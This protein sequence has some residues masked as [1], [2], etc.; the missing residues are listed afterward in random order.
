MKHL[1]G[2]VFSCPECGQTELRNPN[3]D[4]CPACGEETYQM[5]GG[6][7][8]RCPRCTSKRRLVRDP[9]KAQRR[10]RLPVAVGFLWILLLSMIASAYI[11]QA[12]T[13]EY[14]EVEL[15]PDPA[16]AD[17]TVRQELGEDDIGQL[18]TTID[19][20][21]EDLGED[22]P[23]GTYYGT[24]IQGSGF[25][26]R[27]RPY[28]LPKDD[29]GKTGRFSYTM[30]AAH[31]NFSASIIMSGCSEWW[32]KVPVLASSI[33]WSHGLYVAL[34]EDSDDLDAIGFDEDPFYSHA[35]YVRPSYGGYAPD[36]IV[37]YW[38]A[39]IS[40]HYG[41]PVTEGRGDLHVANGHVYVKVHSV[42]KPETDYI[43][44]TYFRLPAAGRLRT[45]WTTAESPAGSE[46]RLCFADYNIVDNW[47][48]NHTYYHNMTG[49]ELTTVGMDLDWSF[50][51]TEGVGAGLFGLRLPVENGT[52]I[53]LVPFFNTT[54]TG[55]GTIHMSFMLPW[56]SADTF[57][58]TFGV[59]NLRDEGVMGGFEFAH[60]QF[61]PNGG[62][63]AAFTF[64]WYSDLAWD[65]DD[66]ALFSTNWT[67]D[68]DDASNPF[69]EDDQWNVVVDFYFHNA[70]NLTLL[71][72]DEDRAPIAWSDVEVFPTNSTKW[73]FAKNAIW[74]S[75]ESA[76]FLNYGV[77]CSARGTTGQWAIRS[78]TA[79]GDIVLTHYFP[80]RIYLSTAR[81]RLLRADEVVEL[82][83]AEEAWKE[84]ND[85]WAS[86]HYALAIVTA[87]KAAILTVWEGVS[88]LKGWIVD[89]LTS[90]W[91]GM[92]ALGHWLYTNLVSFFEKIVNFF[93][94]LADLTLDIWDVLRY[95]VAPVLLMAVFG[96]M[97]RIPRKWLDRGVGA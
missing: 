33:E 70:G 2:R 93:E 41:D 5:A 80:S 84:A 36:D 78:Q 97:T 3:V 57:S 10:R 40:S 43:L 16:F 20:W 15:R 25:E 47:D 22:A 6:K 39:N 64:S 71:C 12:A 66:F 48:D 46:T 79:S 73:P 13:E 35:V 21:R 9:A 65:Y 52:V 50:I 74:R 17:V 28:W 49:Q 60:W 96:G 8:Y 19:V 75:D 38:P 30:L 94:D 18:V 32:L 45:I 72:F 55:D 34:W 63:P 81:Y 58:M 95:L 53:S 11:A 42:I 7:Y 31:F 76:E 90:V 69:T 91:E 85:L 77:M 27:Y 88:A 61:E 29:I 82:S 24:L 44:A 54:T 86:K 68:F 51:F 67:L 92:K 56:F 62:D 23:N 26:H 37:A 83:P 4:V 14:V 89:G 59:R 87:I 1:R